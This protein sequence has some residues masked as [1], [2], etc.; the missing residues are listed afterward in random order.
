MGL[1]VLGYWVSYSIEG[2]RILGFLNL[3]TVDV[4]HLKLHP[5]CWLEYRKT[6]EERENEGDEF[7]V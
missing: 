7:G 1:G 2:L 4:W 6:R 3:I 5:F